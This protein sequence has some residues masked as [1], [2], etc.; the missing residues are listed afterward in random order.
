MIHLSE[1]EGQNLCKD[2]ILTFSPPP[3]VAPFLKSHAAEEHLAELMPIFEQLRAQGDLPCTYPLHV[4]SFGTAFIRGG[5]RS[6][7]LSPHAPHCHPATH[8]VSLLLTRNSFDEEGLQ[9][10]TKEEKCK[11][12]FFEPFF[13]ERKT[14]KNPSSDEKGHEPFLIHLW[15]GRNITLITFYELLLP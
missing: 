5:S 8:W 2:E 14:K 1:K 13:R 6:T 4:S 12:N 9:R 7:P 3:I 15:G 10:K 11:R